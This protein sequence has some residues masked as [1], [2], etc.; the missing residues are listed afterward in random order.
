LKIRTTTLIAL[1]MTFVLT[2]CDKGVDVK[3]TGSN[4][5]AYR[6]SINKAWQ[7]MTEEQQRAYNWAVSGHSLESLA[8]KY[9]EMTPRKIIEREADEYIARQTKKIP[10]LKAELAAKT[11]QLA[12]EEVAV[13][14]EEAKLKREEDAVQRVRQ[15]LMKITAEGIGIATNERSS[16]KREFSFMAHNRS[17]YNIS[18]AGWNAWLFINDEK[19]SDRPCKIWSFYKTK[20][21]LST[22]E[23]KKLSHDIDWGFDC[24]TWGTLEVRQSNSYRF[25]LELDLKSVEDF[26]EKRILPQQPSTQAVQSARADRERTATAINNITESI[27]NTGKEIETAMRMRATLL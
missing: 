15:E 18:S 21:G 23:S 19:T 16:R 22:G 10:E 1:L 4:E 9:P 5:T 25:K 24:R 27:T 14:Q 7:D 3:L 11:E 13:K 8:T 2:G 26:A 17:R 6:A 20:G 12:R